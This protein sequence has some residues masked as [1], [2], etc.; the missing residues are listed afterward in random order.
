MKERKNQSL[1]DFLKETSNSIQRIFRVSKSSVQIRDK[2]NN[3][4]SSYSIITKKLNELKTDN[5]EKLE[6]TDKKHVWKNEKCNSLSK[7]V[8]MIMNAFY[9]SECINY[10]ALDETIT[11]IEM[12][13][14]NHF[15]FSSQLRNALSKMKC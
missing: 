1:N 10:D 7:Q 11:N 8:Y 6:K 9:C 2:I 14:Q 13:F 3:T 4:K 15:S 12:K 5:F